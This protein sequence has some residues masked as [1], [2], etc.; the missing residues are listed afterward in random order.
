M[1]TPISAEGIGDDNIAIGAE[2]MT[3]GA[4]ATGAANP[5]CPDINELGA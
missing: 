1:G 5:F 4:K 2:L 3:V